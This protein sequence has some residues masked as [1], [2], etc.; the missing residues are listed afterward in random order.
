MTRRIDWDASRRKRN[1]S[2]NGHIKSYWDGWKPNFKYPLSTKSPRSLAVSSNAIF[3]MLYD[4]EPR[5]FKKTDLLGMSADSLFPS[6]KRE[7]LIAKI[8]VSCEDMPHKVRELLWAPMEKK[9]R[10]PILEKTRIYRK[11]FD[12]FLELTWL[13]SVRYEPRYRLFCFIYRPK[14]HLKKWVLKILG[15]DL[16]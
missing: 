6:L 15:H 11:I 10:R 12:R 2:K 14:K 1:V 7:L 5:L 8:Q 9:I 3:E 13:D 4:G 16:A